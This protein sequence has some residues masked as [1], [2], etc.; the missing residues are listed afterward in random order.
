VSGA[1]GE[2]TGDEQSCPMH[3]Q[4]VGW[5]LQALEPDEELAVQAHLPDCPSC[6]ETV[7][8]TEVLVGEMGAQ[9]EQVDPQARLRENILAEAA[10]TPQIRPV[11]APEPEPARETTGVPRFE[12]DERD[13]IVVGPA[14]S[15]GSGRR[16]L[17]AAAV[18]L[19]AV[20]GVGGLTVYTLQVQEQRDAQVAQSQ[21]L[22]DLVTQLDRPGTTLATLSTTGGEA[23]AAVLTTIS[24]RTV[25]TAGLPPNDRGTAIYVLWG[26]GVG[27]PRPLGAFDVPTPGAGVHEV[28]TGAGGPA[29]LQYAV[30]LEPGRVMPAAPTVVVASGPVRG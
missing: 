18:A 6:R 23:V 11:E 24:E 9:V 2:H 21:S 13:R 17:V 25:V 15:R 14:G 8:E 27:D 7:R 19:V 28:G 1:H 26:L 29:F 5:A 12:A 20:F 4:A 16:R 10:G 30:S 22:A 3:A